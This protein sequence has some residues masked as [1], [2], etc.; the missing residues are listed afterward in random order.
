MTW[1]KAVIIAEEKCFAAILNSMKI[2]TPEP[3]KNLA[4]SQQSE[5]NSTVRLNMR[6]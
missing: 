2:F 3:Q 5:Y 1:M 4:I 6:P